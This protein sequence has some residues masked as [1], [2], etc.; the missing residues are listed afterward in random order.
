MSGM[1]VAG[2]DQLA[3]AP[4][5]HYRRTLSINGCPSGLRELVADLID[6]RGARQSSDFVIFEITTSPPAY[7]RIA[8]C[9]TR[10]R[11]QSCFVIDVYARGAEDGKTGWDS[12]DPRGV[13]QLLDTVLEVDGHWQ[14]YNCEIAVWPWRRDE[15]Y[16]GHY[17]PDA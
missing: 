14:L 7:A 17:P 1:V 3:V 16:A 12:W 13:P 4:S 9:D 6:G 10:P 11:R 5:T 8:V 15:L 2:M